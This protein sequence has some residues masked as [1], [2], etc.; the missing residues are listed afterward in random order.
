MTTPYDGPSLAALVAALGPARPYYV[1]AGTF[2]QLVYAGRCAL[3]G[4]SLYNSTGAGR[5]RTWDGSQTTGL[6]I[7]D[8]YFPAIG[9]EIDWFGDAG[10]L[11]QRGLYVTSSIATIAGTYFLVPLPGD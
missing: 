6:R 10:I 5:A 11:L 4:H 1:A 7:T 3:M 9:T 2:P 8:V